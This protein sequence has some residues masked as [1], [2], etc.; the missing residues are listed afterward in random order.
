MAIGSRISGHI[1]GHWS[2][3]MSAAVAVVAFDDKLQV[4]AHN[5]RKSPQPVPKTQPL[6]QAPS[7]AHSQ[8]KHNCGLRWRLAFGTISS[9]ENGSPRLVQCGHS[10]EIFFSSAAREGNSKLY[11]LQPQPRLCRIFQ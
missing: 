7:A 8:S 1:Y 6:E 3:L 9:F 4:I 11:F 2:L 5:T 10:Q